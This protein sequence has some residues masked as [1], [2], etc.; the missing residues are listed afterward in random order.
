ME[1]AADFDADSAQETGANAAT[2]QALR[3]GWGDAYTIGHD[4]ENG[5]HAR[6]RDGRGGE[7]TAHG[8]DE[9]WAEIHADYDREPVPRD[10]S[11]PLE[12]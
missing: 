4:D 5:W 7:L 8:P 3:Y 12:D 6:R 1:H 2:L 9:L 11:A 10:Y